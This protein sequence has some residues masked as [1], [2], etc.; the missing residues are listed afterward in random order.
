[1]ADLPPQEQ[2]SF[3]ESA[4]RGLPTLWEELRPTF[5]FHIISAVI[6]FSFA[7]FAIVYL[8]YA[9]KIHSNGPAINVAG[10]DSQ[11]LMT[12]INFLTG[13]DFK[14]ARFMISN[15]FQF[16]VN[17][18]SKLTSGSLN[19]MNLL[20]LDTR[21]KTDMS[22]DE[23]DEVKRFLNNGGGLILIG[24]SRVDGFAN[25]DRG[26]FAA[27]LF[28]I[29]GIGSDLS[30]TAQVY[31]ADDFGYSVPPYEG[32]EGGTYGWT[33]AFYT[34]WVTNFVKVRET[35]GVTISPQIVLADRGVIGNGRALIFS[36]IWQFSDEKLKT[37]L[38]NKALLMNT[39]QFLLA[40]QV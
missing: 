18:F 6:S 40:D 34:N 36:N 19:G 22:D 26:E 3:S 24:F 5:F 10:F 1:M 29:F 17:T 15:F 27:R 8:A 2:L 11:R 9:I 12:E 39:I 14:M 4:G 21:L 25:E 31:S 30:E 32:F 23:I 33:G 37:Y 38:T 35:E 20:Y 16:N 13:H 28:D 7:T